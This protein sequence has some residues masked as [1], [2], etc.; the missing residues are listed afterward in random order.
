MSEANAG[1]NGPEPQDFAGRDG[2]APRDSASGCARP[3]GAHISPLVAWALAFGC[4]V[5]WGSFV[6]PG[7]IFLPEAGP[8]GT[9]LGVFIGGI[10]MAVIAWNYHAMMNSHP[11]PGGAYTY[12]KEAFGIDHGFLCAW[13][14]G[15]TYMAIVW[16]NAT[17]LAIVGRYTLGGILTFG[18]RYTV[19]GFEVCLGDIIVAA[20]VIAA[21]AAVCCRRRLAGRAQTTAALGLAIGVVFCFTSALLKHKGGVAS[22][23]PAFSPDGASP[24]WQVL[25]IIA[26]SPWLF[27]GF[28]GISHSSGEF[29]FPVRRSFGVMAVALVVSVLAYAMLAMLPVLLPPDGAAN[30]SD[31]LVPHLNLGSAVTLPTFAALRRSLGMAGVALMGITMLSAIFTGIVGNIFATSRLLVAMSDDGIIPDWF[32]RHNEDGSPRNAVL[33]VAGISF[34]I[35]FLGRTAI[36]FIVDVSTVGAAIAY[37]YT[38]AAT[39]RLADG[40]RR[41]SITGICG[42]V[43]SVAV[44]LLF[45]VPNYAS[46]AMMATE[47]YLLLVLWCIIGFLFFRSILH[48]DKLQRFGQSTVVWIAILVIIAIMSLMWMRQTTGDTTHKVFDEVVRLHDNVLPHA[49]ETEEDHW[50]TEMEKLRSHMDISLMRGGLVQTGL[51]ALAFAIMFNLHSIL[52]QREHDLEREKALRQRERDHEREK[53]RARSYFFSTVSHDIRT[54]LNAI[55]GFSEMLKAGF[56]TE[57][58]RQ[59]AVDSIIVSGQTLLGLINDVLDL[60]KLESGKMEITP[61]ATD[62]PKLLQD[63]LDAFRVAGSK[64]G[65]ALRLKAGEMPLLLLDPQRLRQIVFNLVGN[66]VKFTKSGH[67]EIR[68]SYTPGESGTTGLFRLDVEDTGCGISEAD[69]RRI[70]SAYVQVGSK[71]GRNGGTGLG[72]AICKQLAAAMGGELKVASTLGKGSTFSVVID[73]VEA[74]SVPSGPAVPLAAPASELAPGAQN[75]GGAGPQGTH[76]ARSRRILIVDD[77]KMNRMVLEALLKKAG[78]FDVAMASD[79]NEALSVIRASGERSFDLVLTDLW[80][81]NLDGAGLVKA[82]RADPAIAKLRVIAVTA[83]VEFRGKAHEVGFDGMLLKPITTATLDE[84]LKGGE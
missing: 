36:G 43:L 39:W 9:L 3:L 42:V 82:I 1:R 74:A 12:A 21:G 32:G 29:R 78:D 13:F 48:R 26:L 17:A 2:P 4:A 75:S 79:G 10:V 19:A 15:L 20:L 14:L 46:G 56:K 84:V 44:L 5:G 53:A 60:S 71:T 33:A 64:P 8:L 66:A 30:W 34:L 63:I 25:R 52:R 72:L 61:E 22:M 23:A 68:A 57:A 80:M 83:D 41:S 38:S 45:I 54:P 18:F 58:E 16:A 47:S 65:L 27:V 62:C 69:L 59:Q 51:L 31:G 11:G 50:K 35:P 76:T 6:M 70:A 81:P 49:D 24:V 40:N 28:E 73:D 7:N 37:A 77:S 55:I 67:V